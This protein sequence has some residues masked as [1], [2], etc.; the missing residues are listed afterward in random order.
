MTIAPPAAVAAI[1]PA[2]AGKLKVVRIEVVFASGSAIA[3]V[4]APVKAIGVSSFSVTVV[5]TWL[6]GGSLTPVTVSVTVAAVEL[7]MASLAV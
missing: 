6:T 3:I 7:P 2:V 5:G 4:L 1:A